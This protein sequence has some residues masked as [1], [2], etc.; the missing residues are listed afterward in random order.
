VPGGSTLGGFVDALTGL[1]GL[2]VDVGSWATA[3]LAAIQRVKAARPR[4]PTNALFEFPKRKHQ[5]G[6]AAK[7]SAILSGNKWTS[8]QFHRGPPLRYQAGPV[9]KP[10]RAVRLVGP[11]A[12]QGIHSQTRRH[13]RPDSL[14]WSG[15][16]PTI[17]HGRAG[18]LRQRSEIARRIGLDR[19]PALAEPAAAPRSEG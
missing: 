13:P 6:A 10:I 4:L 15:S 7:I 18:Y 19:K 1:G 11:A 8:T 17:S 12:N 16:S 14:G 9:I 5:E 2:Q 3:T